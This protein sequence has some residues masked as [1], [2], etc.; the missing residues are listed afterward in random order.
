MTVSSG[1]KTGELKTGRTTDPISIALAWYVYIKKT[2]KKCQIYQNLDFNYL[3]TVYIMLRLGIFTAF[4]NIFTA[5]I[6]GMWEK[7]GL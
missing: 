2:I 1:E 5:N 3:K 6:L 4:D 7:R